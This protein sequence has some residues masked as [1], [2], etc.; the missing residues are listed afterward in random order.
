[1]YPVSDIVAV[2]AA[3]REKIAADLK[4]FVANPDFPCVG[5]KAALRRHQL[6]IVVASDIRR[7]AFDRIVTRW[8]QYFAVRHDVGDKM[9]VSQAVIFMSDRALSEVEFETYLWQRLSA[10]H[11]IDAED[12]HWDPNVDSD[13]DSPHFS[14]SLGGK[15]FFVVGLHP[16]SSRVARRFKY[17]TLVFNMHAQFEKLRDEGRY[18]TL[19]ATTIERDIALQGSANPMLARHGKGSAAAQY[20]G[21][22]VGGKWKC[23]FRHA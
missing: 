19:R 15:G 16:N 3:E 7:N 12:F 1:M 13:P 5:A 4:E 11:A 14:L 10:F 2:T 6:E 23:P 20:S 21:R 22:Q 17:P 8:L 18:E 9:F